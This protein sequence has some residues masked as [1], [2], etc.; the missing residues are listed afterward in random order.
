MTLKYVLEAWDKIGSDPS[1]IRKEEI[2]SES[3]IIEHFAKASFLALNTMLKYK[4][5]NI[6]FVPNTGEPV[7]RIWKILNYLA[8]KSGADAADKKLLSEAASIDMET[9]EA[10]NRILTGDLR[11]GAGRTLFRK[12]IINIP[13]HEPMLCI[14]DL[15]RFLQVAGS[16]EN[17]A[18]SIKL[19]GVR[20]WAVV[21]ETEIRYISR[22]GKDYPNFSI[23]DPELRKATNKLVSPE[24][25]FPMI[26]DGEVITEDKDFQKCL[27]NFRKLKEA[28]LS[29]FELHVF[30][31]VND[32][33]FIQRYK[34]ISGNFSKPYS[35]KQIGKVVYVPHMLGILTS[36]EEILEL[37]EFVTD[38]G[39]EGLVLKTMNGPY[40]FKRS[41]H[42]C[43]IKKF[44]SEDLEVLGLEMGTGRNSE[45]LGALIC[46][47]DGVEVKVGSGYSDV[48]RKEFLENPPEM[49]EVQFQNI[50]KDRSLRFPTFKRVREDK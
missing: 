30:D 22:N 29:T 31:I 32:L 34:T 47:F 9:I 4:I 18:S 23:F 37:L 11:C 49:I 14:D 13:K 33:S 50:T 2:I 17:I 19:D 25:P 44:H 26:F 43:K 10:V 45:V 15:D 28:D 21:N 27:S 20:V 38:D 5:R 41:N 42:W 40:E 24:F 48:E 1:T 7:D 8:A 39:E 12:Y 16:F 35:G 3:L 6:E 46:D 36:K